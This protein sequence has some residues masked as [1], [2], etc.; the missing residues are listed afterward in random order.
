[1]KFIIWALIDQIYYCLVNRSESGRSGGSGSGAGVS[2][3]RD[4]Q[5]LVIKEEPHSP[6]KEVVDDLAPKSRPRS[7]SDK[8]TRPTKKHVVDVYKQVT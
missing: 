7:K 4:G 5:D 2:T 8:F 6:I 1:M 3:S